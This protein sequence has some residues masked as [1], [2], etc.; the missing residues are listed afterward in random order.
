[1]YVTQTLPLKTFYQT[2]ESMVDERRFSTPIS[3]K[4]SDTRALTQTIFESTNSKNRAENS[5]MKTSDSH[6]TVDD[7]RGRRSYS[8]AKKS[9]YLTVVSRMPVSKKI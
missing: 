1:M 2:R 8:S 3:T 7:S 5:P 9:K 4:N 6:F